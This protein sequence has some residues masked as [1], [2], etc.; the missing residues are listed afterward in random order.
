MFLD[1]IRRRN[2][3]LVEQTIALHQ[4]GKLPANSY[5]IDLDAVEANARVIAQAAQKH[6][7]KVYAMT[8]QMGRNASF[9]RAA[10][11]GG[12]G[13]AV[14]VDMECAR[15]TTRAGMALGH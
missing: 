5:V 7:L 8:K 10:M 2:P 13:S 14:A 9:C 1:L 12:I 11:R 6:R 3:K 15:A 4:A